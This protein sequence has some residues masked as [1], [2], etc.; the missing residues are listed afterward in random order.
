MLT[1][2]VLSNSVKNKIGDKLLNELIVVAD[3]VLRNEGFSEGVRMNIE[4]LGDAE[5]SELNERYKNT[6]GPTDVLSF[7]YHT[8]FGSLEPE[9]VIGDV[10]IS[11]DTA[12]TNAVLY[13]NSFKRELCLLVIHGVL[14]A[15]G[16]QHETDDKAK[17]N[18]FYLKQADYLEELC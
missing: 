14:Q 12:E 3:G 11:V 5:I 15:I 13:N 18:E 7:D 17:A 9:R 16:Y 6:V 8:D 10:A 2:I 4:L 1:E